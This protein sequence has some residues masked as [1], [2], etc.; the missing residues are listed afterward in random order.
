MSYTNKLGRYKSS[1]PIF[2]KRVINCNGLIIKYKSAHNRNTIVTKELTQVI[3]SIYNHMELPLAI[4]YE[5]VNDTDY[6]YHHFSNA[7]LKR[8]KAYA[9]NIKTGF[10]IRMLFYTSFLYF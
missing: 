10:D 9:P 8:H 7:Q 3:F 1:D 5:L 2:S 4:R 6:Y